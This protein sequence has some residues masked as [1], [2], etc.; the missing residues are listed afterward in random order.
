MHSMNEKVINRTEWG[1][2][3]LE[4]VVIIIY[5]YIFLFYIHN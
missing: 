3:A 5:C 4:G 1:V 2:Q